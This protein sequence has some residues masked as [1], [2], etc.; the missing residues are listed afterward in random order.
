[1]V[2]AQRSPSVRILAVVAVVAMI[3]AAC[4]SSDDGSSTKAASGS[5]TTTVPCPG[6]PIRLTAILSL[7]GPL[8]VPSASQGI[9]DGTDVA[10]KAVNGTC[11]L[12]RPLAVDIC[13]DQGSPNGATKCGREAASNGSLA[14]FGSTGSF[15]TGTSAA[16]LPGVLGAGASVFDLTN[17]RAFSAISALTLVVGGASASAAAGAK[18]ALMVAIDVSITR[19]FMGTAV[20]VAKDL[21]V[22][23]DV[24]WVPPETTDWA[25]I[26]AQVS[27]RKP[28]AIGVAL[29]LM[30]PFINALANEGI[31]PKDVPIQTAVTLMPPE[32]IKQLGSKADGIYLVTQVAPPSDGSN[33]GVKQMQKEFEA[34]GVALDPKAGSPAV[35]TAWSNVHIF[36]DL[37]GK[38]PK[39]E[40]A[41]LDSAKLV[42][43]FKNAPPV[44][45]PEYAPFDFSKNAYPDI[46]ALSGLRLYSRQAMVVRV[47]DG[48]YVPVTPFGDATKPFKIK[49]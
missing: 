22:R 13:D 34:A 23:L 16:N 5:T 28:Q 39:Q 24:L 4:S 40:I 19:T 8:S 30:V 12:G 10:L 46:A 6:D 2:S 14:L 41:T 31:T 44:S 45:R 36:A 11:Q 15:D 33:P 25:P 43:V 42:D 37:V 38:L 26:A 47:Q 18:K 21:G 7:T 35:V 48:K 1:M 29:P 32:Q 27:E 9:Q 17:P 49:S 20:D 3:A